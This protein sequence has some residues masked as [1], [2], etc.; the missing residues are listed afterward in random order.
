MFKPILFL[1][2]KK[3]AVEVIEFFEHEFSRIA[4][5]LIILR[6]TDLFEHEI[7]QGLCPKGAE[8]LIKLMGEP[9]DQRA[10]YFSFAL[11]IKPDTHLFPFNAVN[12]SAWIFG[13]FGDFVA[14]DR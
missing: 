14:L 11:V 1:W 9:C 2:L 13:Q 4:D 7:D 5:G 6:G 3:I 12:A 8:L 10:F